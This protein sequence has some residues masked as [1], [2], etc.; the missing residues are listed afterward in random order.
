MVLEGCQNTVEN[1]IFKIIKYQWQ[2]INWTRPNYQ[3]NYD[4]YIKQDVEQTKLVRQS[5]EIE[6]I[7]AK[8]HLGIRLGIRAQATCFET[9]TLDCLTLQM[10]MLYAAHYFHVARASKCGKKSYPAH[11]SIQMTNFSNWLAE[12]HA[13]GDQSYV[14]IGFTILW[15]VLPIVRFLPFKTDAELG[16][17]LKDIRRLHM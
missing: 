8:Q 12:I 15:N 13:I 16:S 2:G 6:D 4:G 10:F 17:A 3:R 11:V 14:C 9:I 1:P 7:P 5:K